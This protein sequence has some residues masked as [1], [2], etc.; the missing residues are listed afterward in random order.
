MATASSSGGERASTAPGHENRLPG[1]PPPGRSAWRGRLGD[2]PLADLRVLD[3]SNLIAGPLSATFLAD[4]GADVIKIEH[5]TSADSLRT[6]GK[7]HEGEPLWWKYIGRNKRCVTL[8]LH[9]V[10][11][12]RIFVELAAG[13]DVV[14]EN[15]RP[16]TLAKWGLS[17]DVLA[18]SNPGLVMVHITGFGQSGPK[19]SQ[20]GFG[21]IAESMSGFAYRNGAPDGPPTLPPFGLADTVSAMQAS[22]AVMVALHSRALTGL[23]QEVDLAI[24]ESLLPV[25]E[26][27]VAEFD[28]LGH[29]MTRTGSR[30]LMNAPRNVYPT[31]DGR[32]IALS[33]STQSTADRLMALIGASEVALEPWFQSASGRAAHV[34]ELDRAVGEWVASLRADEVIA[35]CERAGTPATLVYTVEDVVADPQYLDRGAIVTVADPVLGEIKMPGVFP[36]LVSTPGQVQWTG[37]AL[38]AHNDEILGLGGLGLDLDELRDIGAI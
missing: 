34:D 24:A 14:V 10:A 16:G 13:A 12:Q 31:Y 11:A 32:W 9:H 36:R 7:V 30:S 23:G 6:H 21:T 35:E 28:Q 20:P 2:G 33:T 19:S 3:A 27:Q 18:S 29:V 26:P 25:L 4:F 38:G 5:P 17:Y 8:D 15:F 22:Y 37:P 1:L